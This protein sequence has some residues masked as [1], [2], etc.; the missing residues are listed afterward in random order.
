MWPALK[1][2]ILLLLVFGALSLNGCR[3]QKTGSTV[4]G[5]SEPGLAMQFA[6]SEKQ[7]ST[8]LDGKDARTANEDNRQVLR[9]QQWIDF[10]YIALYWAFFFYVIGGPM[11]SESSAVPI[12]GKILAVLI[13]VAALADVLE[14][15]G[16]LLALNSGYA[17]SFWP[18]PFAV[19][20]WF[21][22]YLALLCAAAFFIF[23]SRLGAFPMP[24][25]RLNWLGFFIG[26]A[27]AASSIIGL[28]GILGATGV[29]EGKAPWLAA[30]FLPLVGAI[31]LLLIWFIAGVVIRPAP[32]L[33]AA[34]R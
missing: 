33:R 26:I 20:K 29:I 10:L 18:F 19:T 16:I 21:C 14:D 8:L 11:R 30:A 5:I 28:A 32:A 1:L 17:G 3:V 2:L 12:L 23:Y 31:G 24:T 15:I 9:W 6:T 7:V 27:L 22:F 34:Q 4:A 25:S 13:T